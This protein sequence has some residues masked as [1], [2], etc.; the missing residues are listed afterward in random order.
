MQGQRQQRGAA[1]RWLAPA[2]CMA[3]GVCTRGRAAAALLQRAHARS[4]DVRVLAA[5]P[6]AR[7][8]ALAQ[9]ICDGLT[10]AQIAE[11]YPAEYEARK[12]DKLR[13][14]C[15]RARAK[16]PLPLLRGGGGAHM[17]GCCCCARMQGRRLPHA[18]AVPL[19]HSLSL[20][21]TLSL[22]LARAGTRAASRI[23]T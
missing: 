2:G 12:K 20:S 3:A 19:T 18:C 11:R 8:P 16:Q 15:A 1:A 7:A 22:A 5:A 14:R 17:Q 13:Y 4:A 10:Y 9:G 6:R 23:S 21:H